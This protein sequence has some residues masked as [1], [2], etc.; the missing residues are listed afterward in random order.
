[1]MFVSNYKEKYSMKNKVPV[2]PISPQKQI[3]ALHTDHTLRV[4]Q[5]Y[6][7]ILAQYAVTHGFVDNPF[8][9]ESRMTWIKPSYLWMMYRCGWGYK[10]EG[11]K[12]I[13]AIDISK[14][15]FDWALQHSCTSH[16]AEHMDNEE[17]Q[18]F[19][20]QHPV[21]IQWDPERNL[22][23][24]PLD[25]RAIQI[26]LTGIAVQHYIQDWVV[27]ITDITQEAQHVHQLV[28]EGKLDEAK[29]LLPKETLYLPNISKAV[30]EL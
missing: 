30:E 1:M 12:S 24:E 17:W 18:A 7:P 26:G 25:Y 6:N 2:T 27:N 23:L 5:A 8:F 9:K 15:G 4:Y 16:K 10:D 14:Q 20:D 3:R 13:L 29:A 21:R 11:Q 19:K 22:H 28:L